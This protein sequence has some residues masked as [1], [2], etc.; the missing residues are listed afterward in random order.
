MSPSSSMAN[1]PRFV[2]FLATSLDGF[3][4]RRSGSIDFLDIFTSSLPPGT[5]LGIENYNASL[6]ALVLG[7]ETFEYVIT[8]DAWPYRCPVLVLS[9]TLK[10]LPGEAP[11]S[12]SLCCTLPE[13][14][15]ITERYGWT[16]VGVDGGKVV[17]SFLSEGLL[18]EICITTMP[19][20][21]GEGRPLWRMFANQSGNQDIWMEVVKSAFIQG[22]AGCVQST[23]RVTRRPDDK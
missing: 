9:K 1:S 21:L 11:K 15:K 22:G 4:A 20:L 5:D 23:F 6:S 18:D 16:R 2:A 7:R 8:Q 12:T 10:M 13:I 17:Q 14:I 19:V 3:T